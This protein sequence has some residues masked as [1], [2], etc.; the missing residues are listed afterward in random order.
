VNVELASVT[1]SVAPSSVARSSV[2]DDA[3]LVASLFAVDPIGTGGV[4]LRSAAHPVRDQWLALLRGLLPPGTAWRRI[5]FNI[6]DGRLL[7]GL[8]LVATLKANRPIAERGVLAEAD[9][10]VVVLTMAER[11]AATRAAR[12]NA[13]LDAGEV[14]M[15]REGVWL[16]NP[17]RVGLVALDEGISDEE[18][19][20][21]SLL[22]RLAFP[23]DLNAVD[24]RVPLLPAHLAD[25]ILAARSL[26]PS[27]TADDGVLEALCAT[28]AALGAG[29]PRVALLALRAACAA[30][31]LDGRRRVL[32]E[33][34]VLAGR[35]VLAP[36]ATRVPPTAEAR[37]AEP[38]GQAAQ[39]PPDQ[40]P[41]PPQQ[42]TDDGSPEDP[43]AD[44][45]AAAEPS[46]APEE[47][48][49]SEP[50]QPAAD[51][52][53]EAVQAAIPAGLLARLRNAAGAAAPGSA[54][55]AAVAGRSGALRSSGARGRPAGVRAGAPQGSARLNVIE[56]LRAAAPWQRL[57]GRVT[58]PGTGT[59]AGA[60]AAERAQRIRVTAEDFRVTR[61]QQRA[62]TLT[63]FV[64][65]ASGS[66]ALNRL[67]EAKG[68]VELL[69]A[70]C[71][72]RRDQVAVIG[73]R[74]RTAE[75][76]LPPTRSLVRA[77]RSLAALPGGGGTPLATAIEA[78]HLLAAQALRRGETPTLVLLTDGRANVARDGSGGREVA[79]GQALAA[80]GALAQARIAALF[81]DTSP[82]PN[83]LAQQLAARMHARYVAL[84]HANA[85]ALSGAVKAAV[86]RS[87]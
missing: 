31:A 19:A 12:L 83:P 43:Q 10:G 69:L 64:V 63:V 6:A 1:P 67:A 21:P 79:H 54:S 15:P 71:Y 42:S 51:I 84:P 70:D 38:P 73:F 14:V 55:R 23:L 66:A 13:V 65:D 26:L 11:L 62:Q 57:R 72:V 2:A 25:E 47:P 30:A 75:I 4:C 18:G 77:K 9:G 20:P 16:H 56:T 49:K 80:S 3:A 39:P 36:R 81:I 33:D 32:E 27:V 82:R 34:A 29:S 50:D 40:P 44:E 68:A 22:D 76:L 17:A 8:D 78:A 24:Y 87:G 60:G 86:G 46:A 28:A 74:G 35:L 45:A 7:G 5:P 85:Q 53:L 59:G 61:Y 41:Q 48:Q 37:D 52:V 58:G